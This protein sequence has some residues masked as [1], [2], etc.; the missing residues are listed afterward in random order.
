MIDNGY[1]FSAVVVICIAV[2]IVVGLIATCISD[3]YTSKTYIYIDP[4]AERIGEIT[5]AEDL[6]KHQKQSLIEKAI[7]LGLPEK[8]E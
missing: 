1:E 5:D 8:K 7:A 2:P 3:V 6:D 4:M